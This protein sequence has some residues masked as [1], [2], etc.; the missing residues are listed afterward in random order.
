HLVAFSL[1][2]AFSAAA[3]TLP[4][5]I[6]DAGV[7]APPD[8]APRIDARAWLNQ[9]T[10]QVS[11]FVFGVPL[12]FESQNTLFF[13]NTPGITM[14]GDPGFRF[15]QNRG[16]QRLY[17]DTWV[18]EGTISTDHG[19]FIV[20]LLVNDSRASILQVKATNI[21][22]TGPLLSSGA[23]GLIRLEGKKID[24]TRNGIRTGQSPLLN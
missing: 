23:H 15:V 14:L 19:T 1:T 4:I 22:S 2:A 12:P 17:M 7:F 13:T 10:F 24:L 20:G 9:A 5:Y 18:N 8:L 21:I 11:T 16:G 3:A 6:N